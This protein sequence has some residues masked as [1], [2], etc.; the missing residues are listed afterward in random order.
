MVKPS[1]GL[2]RQHESVFN[3]HSQ[4]GG[5]YSCAFVVAVGQPPCVLILMERLLARR[6]GWSRLSDDCDGLSFSESAPAT[7]AQ[8]YWRLGEQKL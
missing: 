3:P 1:G 6:A 8:A 5:P 4:V 2:R 7:T